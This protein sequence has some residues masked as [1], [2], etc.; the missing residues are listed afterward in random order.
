[1]GAVLAS[2]GLA[3][4]AGVLSILSPCVLPLLPILVGS[5]VMSHRHG[6]LA[7][8]MGLTL[9]FTLAGILLATLGAN[10]GLGQETFRNVAAL[11]LLVFAMVLMLSR[12]QDWLSA[13]ASRLTSGGQTALAGFSLAG[14][15][16][17]FVLGLLLGLVWSPCVGPTLGAAVVLASQ[18]ENLFQVALVMA[19]F[20]VGASVPLIGLGVMS[21]QV[22]S[23]WQGRLL[24]AGKFG[25]R[26]LGVFLLLMAGLV[27]SGTDKQLEAWV[28]DQMPVWLV[29][30][31]TRF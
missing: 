5:A 25:K 15:P 23:G 9:S 13:M 17:Q 8:A 3:W 10:M 29:Q 24:S 6:A 26:L 22:V 30:L 7:L 11:M 28:L 18:G 27:L 2:S 20:G 14:W 19:S 16:G 4:L 21:R 31:T 12:L 1:M